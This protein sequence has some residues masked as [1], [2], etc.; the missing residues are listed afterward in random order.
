MYNR[1]KNLRNQG[2]SLLSE[3]KPYSTIGLYRV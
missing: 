1:P 2:N 3:Q